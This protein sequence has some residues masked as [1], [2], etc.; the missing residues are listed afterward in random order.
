[1]RVLFDANFLLSALLPARNVH[2]PIHII[3]QAAL[4]ER[5]DLLAPDDVLREVER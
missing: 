5:F 1:M 4:D 3:F 2:G